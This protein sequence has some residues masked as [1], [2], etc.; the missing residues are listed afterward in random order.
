VIPRERVSGRRLASGTAGVRTYARGRICRAGGCG[1][2]LSAYNSSTFCAVHERALPRPGR[3]RR[4]AVE[5]ACE[6][7]GASFETAREKQRYCSDRCRMADFVR[8][9]QPVG[10]TR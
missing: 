3:A 4:Q 6:C 8:R 2:V 5:R 10:A 1:T 7:C 9:K